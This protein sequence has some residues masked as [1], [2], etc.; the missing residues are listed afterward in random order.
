MNELNSLSNA[1]ESTIKDSD[2][3][4]VTVGIAEAFTYTIFSEGVLKDI[5]ILGTI[6]GLVKSSL[7]LKDRL[8]LKKILYFLANLNSIEQPVRH[9]LITKI[10]SSQDYKIKVGE[11]LLYIIDKCDDHISAELIGKL[12]SAVLKGKISYKEFL[13]GSEIIDR[14]FFSDLEMFLND[15]LDNIQKVNKFNDDPLTEFQHRLVNAGICAL[16]VDPIIIR[17]QDDWKRSE[18]YIVEGG[19]IGIYITEI[20]QIIR[21][22]L[23]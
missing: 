2:L 15:N 11:K 17:D 9:K 13:Q 3:Q 12:F 5:P 23:R 6:V 19:K 18:R 20:G 14:A 8:F 22:Q 10:D 21:H 1:L 7:N 4:N 16:I